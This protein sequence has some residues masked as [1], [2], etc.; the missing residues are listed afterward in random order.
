MPRNINPSSGFVENSSSEE[1]E[2][3][4]F[5]IVI[6]PWL[7]ESDSDNFSE[8]EEINII[9]AEAVQGSQLAAIESFKGDETGKIE[10]WVA[11]IDRAQTQFNWNDVRTAAAAKSKLA[12]LAAKWI[13]SK[14]Q[15]GIILNTWNDQNAAVVAAGTNLRAALLKRFLPGALELQATAA[16]KEVQQQLSTESINSYYDRVVIAVTK[17]HRGW[18][19]AVKAA[20]T[21]TQV[22]AMEVYNLFAAGMRADIREKILGGH[23]PPATD[24]DILEAARTAEA[25]M[26]KAA[27][28][29]TNVIEVTAQ[30]KESEDSPK[31]LKEIMDKVT[32]MVNALKLD[33]AGGGKS[34]GNTGDRPRACFRCNST[35][36]LIARCP[37]RSRGSFQLRRGWIP[38]GR[39][40]GGRG[41]GRGYPRGN[42]YNPNRGGRG[43]W[44]G[45]GSRANNHLMQGQMH[46]PWAH[47]ND[48]DGE[49]EVG[50]NKLAHMIHYVMM[51]CTKFI[52][53]GSPLPHS[54]QPIADTHVAGKYI[55]ALCD[56]GSDISLLSGEMYQNLK[57]KLDGK[58]TKI[59]YQIKVA[60]GSVLNCLGIISV[61]VT[62]LN[63]TRDIQVAVMPGLPM[64]LLL[65]TDAIASFNMTIDVKNKRL[66]F[67][68]KRNCRE[69]LVTTLRQ[70]KLQKHH[71]HWIPCRIQGFGKKIE[72]SSRSIFINGENF[73][74]PGSVLLK[75][76]LY[77]TNADKTIIHAMNLSGEPI[78]IPRGTIVGRVKID[79]K[80]Q[81]PDVQECKYLNAVQLDQLIEKNNVNKVNSS[82]K[83][84]VTEKDV[85]MSKIP[86][87]LRNEY[88]KV[89]NKF[90]E[91][92]AWSQ[93][94]VGKCPVM[95][96]KIN[97]IDPNKISYTP[98][99]RMPE[100]M[101]GVA[102]E[103][104][105]DLISAGIVVPSQ[106]SFC[107]PILFVKKP[108][109]DD[110]SKPLY[111]RI[112]LVVDYRRLNSNIIRDGYP[113]RNLYSL[114]DKVA[115]KPIISVIDI[116]QGFYNQALEKSSRKYTAF[117]VE[118]LGLFEFTRT[119]M[120]LCNSVA[121]FQRMLEFITRDLSDVYCYI[122][123]LVVASLS[124]AEHLVKLEELFARLSKYNIK[125]RP[126]K[127]QLGKTDKIQYLGYSIVPGK[128]IQAGEKKIAVV[129][130]WQPPN[131]I[132]ELRQFTALGSFF[133]RTIKN[134]A[135]ICAPL[136]RLTRKNS[137]WTGGKLPE[138]AL[139][140]FYQLQK[141]LV[142]RPCLKPADWNKEFYLFTDACNEAIGSVLAQQDG[143]ENYS[144]VAYG[145][146]VLSEREKKLS[147]IQKEHLAMVWSAAHFKPYLMGKEFCFK[148]D[149]QPL[150]GLNRITGNLM[151]RFREGLEEFVPYRIEYIKGVLNPS[152]SLSRGIPA[153][154]TGEKL[155]M[156]LLKGPMST[157]NKTDTIYSLQQQD[158]YIKA[159]ACAI[160]YDSLPS[161]PELLDYVM[162]MLPCAYI[163]KGLVVAKDPFTKLY[164]V[165]APT[166]I[167]PML[168]TSA[169]DSVLGGH[170]GV[171]KTLEKLQ[172]WMWWNMRADIKTWCENCVVC[173]QVNPSPA[174]R[175]PLEKMPIGKDFNELVHFD[176]ITNLPPGRRNGAKILLVIKDSFSGFVQLIPLLS[177]DAE[178][179]ANAILESWICNFG[180]FRR[181]QSDL[182][183]ENSNKVMELMMRRL[184]I[185]HR[186]SS[187]FH[188]QSDGLVEAANKIVINKLR[189]F[190]DNPDWQ[191][192]IAPI[193][194]AMNT[195]VQASTGR[196]PYQA[197]FL[198]RAYMPHNI[199]ASLNVDLDRPYCILQRMREEVM[200]VHAE[201]QIKNKIQFDKR[202]RAKKFALGDIA[203]IKHARVGNIPQK[204]QRLYDGP[205]VII[206]VLE[207]NNYKIMHEVL[208]S[209]KII[210]AN[211][212]KMGAWRNQFNRDDDADHDDRIGESEMLKP[213]KV[214]S[215]AKRQAEKINPAMLWDEMTG[216]A[217]AVPDLVMP[218]EQVLEQEER[219]DPDDD[220]AGGAAGGAVAVPPAAAAAAAA[221]AQDSGRRPKKPPP[222]PHAMARRSQKSGQV[223]S[224]Q[225]QADVAATEEETGPGPSKMESGQTGTKK[226]KSSVIMRMHEAVAKAR[227]KREG[228]DV[229][230]DA[231]YYDE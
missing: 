231:S 149:H 60:N 207:H 118:S 140:A 110:P 24:E 93:L 168:L 206:Q 186:F 173:A 52:G 45:R 47:V 115:S 178:T 18:P 175:M 10:Q 80:G 226:K 62:I 228:I 147:T 222:P 59:P 227:L 163:I 179:V 150:L 122:D 90:K 164:R 204:L 167:Q 133:R 16:L 119:A 33:N 113:M 58:L 108:G 156:T 88:L 17:M 199:Q 136:S 63:I 8:E 46:N 104:I 174:I 187:V 71:E 57:H 131:T 111:E 5:Q 25:E 123:D 19:I 101:S 7:F 165:V 105:N 134:F 41:R 89:L 202:A 103:Y 67:K 195:T 205:Y 135:G 198:R 172:D 208:G 154:E 151:E 107:S 196:T 142:S 157:Q 216:P 143:K 169:H 36:H 30:S 72:I 64:N 50:G 82:N 100:N 212:M 6:P 128:S 76:G 48:Q 211:H 49:D 39:G 225:A 27:V 138:D 61:P 220:D 106:S 120:G 95:E 32:T 102:K 12:E 78:V 223:P 26:D 192:F 29:Y 34:G 116:S 182:G 117:G 230:K 94:D 42:W 31:S 144:P 152:D 114:L 1:E 183:K 21:Y 191:Q 4:I 91:I 176:L 55:R 161:S 137:G 160:K 79:E 126:N 214:E 200:A 109:F 141:A 81:Q 170:Y 75:S 210:H 217:G 121:A 162:K 23:N 185:T 83:R 69:F 180:P 65:G 86:P 218:E 221:A 9:M 125:I 224:A 189:K 40:F 148:V 215:Y 153:Y 13:W 146:R 28:K 171:E 37:Q 2:D 68:G 77:P 56:T 184:K 74:S 85:E 53:M 194:L 11:S 166:R 159:L 139:R 99:Y 181:C 43:G 87:N 158:K 188:A 197:V 229:P 213:R 124:H 54:Q 20:D 51:L 129:A 92:F 193:Q 155:V 177:K 38:R 209:T 201:A 66:I 219:S 35:S 145:S 22:F 98:P 132:K 203:Y 3:N 127:V 70:F 130:A 190:L 73:K 112:R 44:A 14:E 97:L 15:R 96:Q 84:I